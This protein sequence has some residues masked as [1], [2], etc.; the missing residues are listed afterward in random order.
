M[1]KQPAAAPPAAISQVAT[2]CFHRAHDGTGVSP[3]NATSTTIAEMK[4]AR[5]RM[6]MV[7]ASGVPKIGAR[8]SAITAA[9][10]T[11][12]FIACFINSFYRA[13]RGP[14]PELTGA[15]PMISSKEQNRYP[16]IQW[17]DWVR[18]HSLSR[19]GW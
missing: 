19:C 12:F 16:G 4:P 1:T 13:Y 8:T 14:T 17:S 3:Q 5:E 6:A 9:G 10:T 7:I 11:A 2:R 18:H 15:G